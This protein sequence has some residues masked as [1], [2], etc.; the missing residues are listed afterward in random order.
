M[1]GRGWRP[2]PCS[3]PWLLG[4]LFV[5]GVP[6]VDVTVAGGLPRTEGLCL[7]ESAGGAAFASSWPGAGRAWLPSLS[8]ERRGLCVA[9]R[10]CK[11]AGEPAGRRSVRWWKIDS[12]GI[13]PSLST[14][15][16]GAEG[17]DNETPV[18]AALAYAVATPGEDLYGPM[19]KGLNRMMEV[20]A[21]GKKGEMLMQSGRAVLRE[22]GETA[23]SKPRQ[24]LRA[25]MEALRVVKDC[26]D[27]V[28]FNMVRCQCSQKFNQDLKILL[29]RLH[30]SRVWVTCDAN[31]LPF[32]FSPLPL[33]RPDAECVRQGGHGERPR[34]PGVLL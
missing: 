16:V 25:G 14:I 33:P 8:L 24:A 30:H 13:M 2:R 18:T 10:G 23:R 29:S 15:Q 1:K 21:T 9:R 4:L 12:S 19:A 31:L 5:A 20:A 22:C 17:D 27:V 26:R 7:G 11:P 34:R 32:G 6:G 3:F 28:S